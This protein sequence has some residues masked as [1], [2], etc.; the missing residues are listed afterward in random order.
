MLKRPYANDFL[1]CKCLNSIHPVVISWLIG[2]SGTLKQKSTRR[3]FKGDTTNPNIRRLMS[4]EAELWDVRINTFTSM[5]ENFKRSDEIKPGKWLMRLLVR[6][7]LLLCPDFEPR[8]FSSWLTCSGGKTSVSF[9]GNVAA[10]RIKQQQQ[11]QKHILWHRIL[12]NLCVSLQTGIQF[13]VGLTRRFSC[14]TSFFLY[15]M[16][17]WRSQDYL[18][19][20]C[21]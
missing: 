18:W 2:S 16:F 4:D 6:P 7:V 17:K 20:S 1:L 10:S 8:G 5:C 13:V 11:Q 14:L 12:V 15:M 21:T 19:W 3:K 9:S